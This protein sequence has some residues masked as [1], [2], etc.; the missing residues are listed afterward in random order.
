MRKLLLGMGYFTWLVCN[1]AVIYGVGW[2]A[3]KL[4]EATS[5]GD[6]IMKFTF[7]VIM[8][9]LL[10]ILSGLCLGLMSSMFGDEQVEKKVSKWFPFTD[11]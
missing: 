3:M 11:M 6:F 1:L 2:G 7:G 8:L 4:I 9:F 5:I 10:V